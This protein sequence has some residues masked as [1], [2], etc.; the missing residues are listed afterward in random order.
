[1]ISVRNASNDCFQHLKTLNS[2]DTVFIC[3]YYSQYKLP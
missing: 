2:A 3:P 1:V